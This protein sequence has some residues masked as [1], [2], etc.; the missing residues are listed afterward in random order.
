VLHRHK[1][2]KSLSQPSAIAI[3]DAANLRKAYNAVSWNDCSKGGFPSCEKSGRSYCSA[4]IPSSPLSASRRM[5]Y[6]RIQILD[7]R[8][9]HVGVRWLAL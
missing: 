1:I 8:R 4:S 6:L 9:I 2:N 5:P 7:Q 3:R